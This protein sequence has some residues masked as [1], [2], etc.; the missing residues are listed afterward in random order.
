MSTP[1][2]ICTVGY[3]LR[4][5]NVDGRET[6]EIALGK[7]KDTP[8]ARKLR[9][10]GKRNGFGGKLKSTDAS[11]KACA[12]REEEEELGVRSNPELLEKAGVVTFDNS[13]FI[14]ECHFFFTKEW[15]GE[16]A[17]ETREFEDIRWFDLEALPYEEMM[18]ADAKLGLPQLLYGC[19]KRGI[20]LRM[21]VAHDKE[22]RMVKHSAISYEE[23]SSAA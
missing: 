18:D 22:M 7:K 6:I 19:L 20:V 16:I 9:M 17:G 4:T 21:A 8:G 13:S 14:V 23:T 11:I 5:R 12:V 15:R 2:I 3:L 1:D 10:V